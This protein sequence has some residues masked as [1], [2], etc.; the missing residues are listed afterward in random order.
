MILHT[1]FLIAQVLVNDDRGRIGTFCGDTF[2]KVWAACSDTGGTI[3]NTIGE[4]T[5]F[6]RA[7][8]YLN[9]R[10]QQCPSRVENE[11]GVKTRS[12]WVR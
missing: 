3:D 10:C 7:Q 2:E 8:I 5:S 9:C 1:S 4:E 6:M 12:L 11:G